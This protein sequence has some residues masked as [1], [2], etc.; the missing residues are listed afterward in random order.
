MRGPRSPSLFLVAALLGAA[1]ADEPFDSHDKAHGRP[2]LAR[3]GTIG[4]RPPP[5]STLVVFVHADGVILVDGKE[6]TLDGLGTALA[7]LRESGPNR[8]VLL[9][10]DA[11]L[12]WQAMGILLTLCSEQKI[13]RVFH[14]VL[15]ETGDEEG[16]LLW[17]LRRDWLN[18]TPSAPVR[19]KVEIE[20]GGPASEPAQLYWAV[21]DAPPPDV[22][23][24][25]G[26]GVPLGF[27]I[28]TVD[29]L[30][31]AGAGFVE[32]RDRYI[33][34]P[35][36][37]ARDLRPYVKAQAGKAQGATISLRFANKPLEGKAEP[38]P[39][40][41]RVRG[42]FAGWAP[43]EDTDESDALDERPIR[44]EDDEPIDEPE[45]L[46][47]AAELG[48]AWLAAHQDLDGDGK[49]D[50]AAF[51]KHDP[52]DDKSD[53]AGAAFNDVGVTGLAVLAFLGAGYTDRGGPKE[54]RYAK[55]VRGGLRYLMATQA[56]DGAFGPREAQ[57]FMYNQAIATLA[58]SEACW[59][60]GNP[61]YKGPAQK[62]LDFL[63]AARNPL[64][65]WRY[66]PRGGDNDTSVTAWCVMALRS[67]TS[68]GLGVDP[69]AFE[70]ARQW[71]D[72]VTDPES[73]RVGYLVRGGPSD[74]PKGMQARWPAAKT[75]AMT[76]AGILTR[77][78]LG[79]DPRLSGVLR[80]SAEL[81]AAAP[82]DWNRDTGTI[83]MDYWYFGTLA[84]F[85]VGGGK[86]DRWGK[87]MGEAIV[88]HQ[89]Q[90]GSGARTGS[91][92]PLGPWGPDGGRVYAT[93]LL[94]MALEVY[95]RYD[96]VFG[97]K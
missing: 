26:H 34:P 39:P 20:L 64:A 24:H 21:R 6:T 28:S 15:P 63:A 67:G 4:D 50:C 22:L 55:H 12:P 60:S 43:D 10:A 30:K 23:L 48:L 86:W 5:E 31:R 77:I 76:A 11:R 36:N 94:T 70:G 51:M 62:G 74:R 7:R 73:G 59:L 8:S 68:A 47:N 97:V 91:W 82:P 92:D 2:E 27:V 54:N 3:V 58:M 18:V 53:G 37:R 35:K 56:D 45:G 44:D 88:K 96:R 80:K 38:M 49:W 32:V 33:P 69:D 95:Y 42:G 9:R 84:L 61:R 16:A 81:C 52:A 25:A 89:H 57:S 41:E 46:A 78:F 90:R 13:R 83:D 65:A 40:V 14:S 17:P 29:A 66:K 93:A 79:A 19:P 87:A 75:E 85:Q 72:H 1:Y 71:I